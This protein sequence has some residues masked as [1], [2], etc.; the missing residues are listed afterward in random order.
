MDADGVFEILQGKQLIYI[1]QLHKLDNPQIELE[2]WTFYI[3][4][5]ALFVYSFILY[6][7]P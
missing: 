2:N 5:C 4:S 7:M 3:M 6:D 1:I